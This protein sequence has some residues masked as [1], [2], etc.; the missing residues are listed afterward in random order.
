MLTNLIKYSLRALKRQ[1]AYVLINI[2]GLSIGLTCSLIIAIF[3]RY[4][5]SYDQYNEYKDQIYRV[6]LHGKIS[7][8]EV[9]VTST[10]S[11]IG[12]TMVNEFPEVENYLRINGWGETII[13]YNDIPFT[14]DAFIEADSS[15]FDFFSIPLLQ[16]QKKYVLNEPHTI[17]LSEST[18]KKIFGDE[19]PVNKMLKVSNDSVLYRVTGVMADIPANTHFDANMIGSFMTNPRASDD[20]WLSNS[21]DTYVMLH[22]DTDPKKVDDRFKGMIEKYV[23]PIITKYFG[24]TLDEF[25]SQG[26]KYNMYLQSL[27]D[28]HLNPE[29]E[30]ELKAANDPKYLW[31]FGS[32][33]LL[34]IIIAS[35][36]FM[37]LSTAQA[38]KRAKEVGIK[39]VSGS[40]RSLLIGQFLM[41]TLML[42]FI[43]LLITIIITEIVLPYFNSMLGTDLHVG[44]IS[45]WY[46][47]PI[48]IAATAFIGLIAG[49]YPAFYLSSFNPYMVL[50]GLR[51]KQGRGIKLRSV[52]VILQFAI[53]IVLIIGTLI[54]FRQ[55]NFM[56]TRDLGFDKEQVFVIRRAFAIGSHTQSFK[57]D[58]RKIPGVLNVATST[59]VPGHNNNNNGYAVKGREEESFL[60]QTNWVDYEYF[61]TYGLKI[62]SGRFFDKSYSTDKDACI[63]NENAV[64]SFIFNDPFSVK[65]INRDDD[66]GETTYMPVIGVVKDFHFESLRSGINPYLMR[67]KNEDIHWGY[68]SIKLAPSANAST[69]S[70]IENVWGSYTNNDPMQSFFMDKDFERM[71]REE[72]QNAKLSILFTILAIFIASLGLYGLTAFTVQQRTKE[73]GVRKTFGASIFNIWSLVAKEILILIAISTALAWPLVYWVASN[74]L[75]NYYYRITLQPTDFLIGFLVAIVIALITISHRTIKTALINPSDSLRYE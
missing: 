46:T 45:H 57:D 12:P 14:E 18:A 72:K 67:F 61:E 23:G 30:Q 3:I 63:I 1:K 7:G 66:T 6:I 39:K 65:F 31:I 34:I 73:I 13:K 2:L 51:T 27:T 35:I 41:E 55:I 26:N 74:W 69:I 58:I 33:G 40:T 5:L 56:L 68:I 29:I 17:V 37:N 53:S 28:I 48:L 8:Q 52:L 20:Q 11:P 62:A 10:A 59:A 25:R 22:H 16:G 36:N 50:K 38:S 4:E 64:K 44:Y 54:M 15:F 75:Q 42:S 32:I 71:Y 21:F 24:I 60:L 49:S 47:I 19:N 70:E 9:Q 43:A